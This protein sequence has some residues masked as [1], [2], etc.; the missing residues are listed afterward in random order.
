MTPYTFELEFSVRDYE[1]DTQGV[2]NNSVYQNYLEHARHEFL[3]SI[4]LN[5][6]K[7]HENGTDAVVHKVELEYKRPLLG[8]DRFVVRMYARQEGNVRFVFYQDI[9]KIPRNELALKGKVTGVFMNNG[10]PIRPPQEVVD[11]LKQD[12]K[13]N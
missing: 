9:Y 12:E 3:K 11:A 1:L 8:D 4:G 6:N 10:R 2:V 5:F 13:P 7:L